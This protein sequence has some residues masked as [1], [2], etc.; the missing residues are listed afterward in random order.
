MARIG[1]GRGS[2]CAQEVLAKESAIRTRSRFRRKAALHPSELCERT[3]G[4]E[5][6]GKPFTIKEVTAKLREVV[7]AR[8]TPSIAFDGRR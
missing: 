7:N 4:I 8:S 2:S 6:I 3:S 5:L 1:P